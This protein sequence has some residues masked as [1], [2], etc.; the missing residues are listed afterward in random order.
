MNIGIPFHTKQLIGQSDPK[1]ASAPALLP[2]NFSL[3]V[4]ALIK[5]SEPSSCSSPASTT[6]WLQSRSE[7]QKLLTP[8]LLCHKDTAP[9]KGHF[10]PFTVSLWHSCME[11][12]LITY[13]IKTQKMPVIGGFGCHELCLYAI[14]E[15]ASATY[16]QSRT[17]SGTSS[18]PVC[19]TSTR[20]FLLLRE[21]RRNIKT[22]IPLIKYC[23]S[24]NALLL[25]ILGSNNLSKVSIL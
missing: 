8:A 4:P 7:I 11:A 14:R 17:S 21:L 23:P 18:V 10:L 16:Y 3:S 6:D 24:G 15:L 1:S 2:L 5:Q 9:N 20:N 12:I 13:V 22:N 19:S 25:T